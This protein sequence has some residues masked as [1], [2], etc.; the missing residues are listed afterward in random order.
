MNGP[1]STAQFFDMN[2][3]EKLLNQIWFELDTQAKLEK[4]TNETFNEFK[5]RIKA[6]LVALVH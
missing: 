1:L 5:E 3:M 4:K 6:H 2:I